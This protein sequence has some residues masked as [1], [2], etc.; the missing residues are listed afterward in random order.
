MGYS[1]GVG[2][3]PWPDGLYTTLKPSTAERYRSV[4]RHHVVPKWGRWRLSSI[5]HSD[6][7]AWVSELSQQGLRTGS[8]RQVHRVL[9]LILD[10]AVLDGRIGRNPASTVRLPRIVRADPRF[11]TADDVERLA[12]AAAPHTGLV[13]V[14][15]FTGL[16]F[17]AR[18]RGCACDGSTW[19]AGGS[20][21][22]RF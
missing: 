8:V 18:W 11:L 21:L 5:S 12:R 16:R 10:A 7:A 17:L 15:A 14:M 13:L 2:S 9:S 4:V 6:V 19:Y 3:P 1:P 22:S 20:T